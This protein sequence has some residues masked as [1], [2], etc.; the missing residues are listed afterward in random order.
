MKH[1][2]KT[3]RLRA[4][5]APLTSNLVIFADRKKIS[6]MKKKVH[7]NKKTVSFSVSTHLCGI[8]REKVNLLDAQQGE[9]GHAVLQPL[10]IDAV[11][12]GGPDAE[13]HFH[14]TSGL[15]ALDHLEE[16]VQ[17]SVSCHIL[18]VLVRWNHEEQQNGTRVRTGKL[19][20]NNHKFNDCSL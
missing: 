9:R 20:G 7:E 17:R 6:V 18:R 4:N 2:H 10:S 14:I 13:G 5:T 16:K 8:I 12:R 3:L 19:E 15:A 1:S 11:E